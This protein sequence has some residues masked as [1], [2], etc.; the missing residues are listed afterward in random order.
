[1]KTYWPVAICVFGI[2]L[3]TLGSHFHIMADKCVDR[4]SPYYLPA[5]RK[6]NNV[7]GYILLVLGLITL[8]FFGILLKIYS[9]ESVD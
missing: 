5:L 7:Q 8:I 3:L 4:E 6:K 2:F 1:M 9:V